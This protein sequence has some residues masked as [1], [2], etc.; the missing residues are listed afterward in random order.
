MPFSE[1]TLEYLRKAGW[2]EDRRIDLSEQ[3]AECEAKGIPLYP[4]VIAFMMRFG[5]LEIRY[6]FVWYEHEKRWLYDTLAI[7][8]RSLQYD[9]RD[10]YS[11]WCIG[12]IGKP[13]SYIGTTD[14]KHCE[15]YMDTEGRVYGHTDD[16]LWCYGNSGEEA[17]EAIINH[18]P[19]VERYDDFEEE[20]KEVYE[21]I[22]QRANDPQP[23]VKPH[24]TERFQQRIKRLFRR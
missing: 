6:P 23:E 7:H 8:S 1:N 18:L 2:S 11:A 19:V 22:K 4:V 12:K 14:S 20:M 13:L 24:T 16:Y 17:I 9:T 10:E 3:I 15:L 5:D 21:S